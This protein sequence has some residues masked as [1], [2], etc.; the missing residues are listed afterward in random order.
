M[1]TITDLWKL[2]LED[3]KEDLSAISIA[4]W[5]DEVSPVRMDLT[6]LYL[7]CPN[8]F[9][10][11]NI[12]RFYI[13]PI[14]KSLHRR[15]S[16][17]IE[18]K[19]LSDEEFAQHV[20]GR[21]GRQRSLRD[22]GKFTF[23]NFVVGDSNRMAYS[24]AQAVAAG[25]DEYCNPLVIYGDPGLGKTHLLNAIAMAVGRAEPDAEIVCLKGDEFTNEMVEAIRD[26]TNAQ[27][28]EKYRNAAVFLMDD[29]Q[30][31]AGKKQTQEEFFNT[32]DALYQNGCSIVLTMD[33]HPRELSRLEERISSRFEG[34]L[35]VEIGEPEY[36]TRFEIVRRKALERGLKLE[37][38]DLEYIAHGVTG[39]VRRIEGVLNKLKA[40]SED[41]KMPSYFK[42]IVDSSQPARSV[43]VTPEVVIDTT[44]RY[45]AV[46]P[47]LIKGKSRTKS[48]MVARQVAMYIL[49]HGLGLTTTRVGK[50]MERDHATVCYALQRIEGK[51]A[52]DSSIAEKIEAIM[53]ELGI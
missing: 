25:F 35:M 47:K 40:L 53:K 22:C 19:F 21:G 41:G 34:G 50:I 33:R 17:D 12:E 23:D 39:S 5:F 42:Q 13:E 8:S 9:K 1:N 38:Q 48:V 14:Q 20:S 52:S 2:V 29:V 11:S 30:F 24:A 3:L 10:Q 46:D 31:I 32:F 15:F 51:A 26:D 7:Y 16:N 6:V 4:T 27:F 36:D 44:A 37:L 45:Y 18:V 49:C 43:N 28:R